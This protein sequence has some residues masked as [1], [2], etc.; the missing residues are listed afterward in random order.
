LAPPQARA[1]SLVI[2]LQ[3]TPETLIARV[4][5]RGVEIERSIGDAYLTILAESYTRF[6]HNY[7]A[8]PVMVVNSEN[9]NFVDRDD[10]FQL[11]VT[12]I[13]AM[14]GHREYFNR[15]E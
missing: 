10:D 6:F 14:R 12:R 11:L 8:A 5:K 13:E 15:G 1:P 7:D 4:R 3:A 9:I 2:Y